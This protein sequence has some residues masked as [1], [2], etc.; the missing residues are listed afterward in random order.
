MDV[1]FLVL[2]LAIIYCH[3]DGVSKVEVSV[4]GRRQG[5]TQKHY[6]MPQARCLSATATAIV[7]IDTRV[8]TIFF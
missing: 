7:Y 6:G 4:N 8:A 5:V 1:F 3:G 2:V